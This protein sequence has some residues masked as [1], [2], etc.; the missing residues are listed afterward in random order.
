ANWEQPGGAAAESRTRPAVRRC[1]SAGH[2]RR[3]IEADRR[4]DRRSLLLGR[5]RGRAR[6]GLPEP[7]HL[8][9]HQARKHRA[10]RCVHGDRRAARRACDRPLAALASTAVSAFS[11]VYHT[12]TGVA[13]W[14]IGGDRVYYAQ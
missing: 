12:Q 14:E 13:G 1:V 8:L 7:A 2:R 4:Y 10:E 11:L 3:Y 9:D 5:E 6:D